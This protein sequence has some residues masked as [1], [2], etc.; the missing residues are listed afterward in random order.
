MREL[1]PP[2]VILAIGIIIFLAIGIHE[3]SHAKFA[4]MA[5]DPTPRLQ[6]RVTL[7]LTRHFEPI[8]TLMILLTS[9]TGYGIGW[10]KPVQVNPLKM[11][12]MVWDHFASVAAG[13]LSNFLQAIIWGLMLRVSLR[14]GLISDEQVYMS[15]LRE[16]AG[17]FPLLCTLGVLIN[18]SL[19]FF[20][21]IP[22][23]PLDGHWLVGAFLP[24]RT[25]ERW[26]LW[27]RHYGTPA[28]IALVILG[29]I[30]GVRTI[31]LFLGPAV[32]KTFTFITGIPLQ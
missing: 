15:L 25:R 8:G 17:F 26:Y 4:D 6:G 14:Q 2:D 30:S 29:Q 3:Y 13:P 31:T 1:P 22:L 16:S 12:N 5:G 23:G 9:L 18:L 32:S 27:N 21:L 20:N 10:G 7:N 11:R 28:L 24:I 19:F